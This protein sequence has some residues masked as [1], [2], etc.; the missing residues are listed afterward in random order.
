MYIIPLTTDPNR[1]F[2][3][4]VT[5]DST[6]TTFLLTTRYNRV[7][8]YW[9]LTIASASTGDIILDSI[10]L[11]TGLSPAANIL[12]QYAYLGIGSWYMVNANSSTLDWPDD[13]DLGTDFVLIVSDT[14]SS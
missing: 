11:I 6:K 8:G 13:T 7:A 4:T 9:V 12:G 5:I 3:C 14:P 2:Q 10:P 1:T